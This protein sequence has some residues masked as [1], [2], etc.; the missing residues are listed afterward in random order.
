MPTPEERDAIT[1]QGWEVYDT[2]IRPKMTPAD[3]GKVVLIDVDSGDYELTTDRE[4]FR[5]NR[6]LKNRRPRGKILALRV[7]YKAATAIGGTLSPD[8][9]GPKRE[10]V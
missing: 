3:I 2:T 9:L 4:T 6:A 5:A 8:P 10:P 1:Q 7:G